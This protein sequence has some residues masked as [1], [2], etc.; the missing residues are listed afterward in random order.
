MLAPN[1]DRDEVREHMTNSQTNLC[2]NGLE[3]FL[4]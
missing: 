2:F 4:R 3:M 1:F